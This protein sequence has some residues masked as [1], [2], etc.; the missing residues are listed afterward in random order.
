MWTIVRKF[1][2]TVLESQ[3]AGDGTARDRAVAD[4]ALLKSLCKEMARGELKTFPKD[5]TTFEGLVDIITNVIHIAT[6]HHTSINYLQQYYMTFVPNFPAALYTPFPTT[7]EALGKVGEKELLAALPITKEREWLMM[8]QVPYLLSFT[9]SHER[10]LFQYATDTSKSTT[11][12]VPIHDAAS[13][14]AADLGNFSKRVEE[15]SAAMDDQKTPY[16][17]MDPKASASSIIL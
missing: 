5:I 9:P 17:V 8:G 11:V 13:D 15:I 3:Y 2:S 4:D 6:T 14:L 12:P 1:V 10:S 7:L 16:L